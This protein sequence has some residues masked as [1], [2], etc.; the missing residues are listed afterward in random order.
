MVNLEKITMNSDLKK[1]Q[2]IQVVKRLMPLYPDHGFKLS[3]NSPYQL[4]IGTILLP[5]SDEKTVNE[6]LKMIFVQWPTAEALSKAPRERLEEL[7]R[8]V[9]FYRQKAKYIQLTARILIERYGGR[10]PLD[11]IELT[12]L[13]GVSRKNANTILAELTGR[14][15]GIVVDNHVR[16]LA[17]RLELAQGKSVETVENQLMQVTPVDYWLLLPQLLMAHGESICTVQKPQCALCPLNKKC[18]SADI[19]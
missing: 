4:V 11:L 14:P 18:P 1:Q 9:G 15:M 16:R 17:Q 13:P 3:Y 2:I 12:K 8:V 5:Q 10:V 19:E 6:L 7:L